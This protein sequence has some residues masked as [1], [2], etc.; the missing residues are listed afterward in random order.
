MLVLIGL[1][2]N[3]T[4]RIRYVSQ[5]CINETVNK[6]RAYSS[7]TGLISVHDCVFSRMDIF[8]P[9][10]GVIMAEGSAT[11]RIDTCIFNHCSS[12]CIGGCIFYDNTQSGDSTLTRL[13]VFNCGVNWGFGSF[14][15]FITSNKQSITISLL[16]ILMCE[17]KIDE[18][19]GPFWLNGGINGLSN[20]N[21]TMN[22]AM[23]E[24]ALVCIQSEKTLMKF[25][26][27]IDDVA[28]GGSILYFA[29]INEEIGHYISFSNF[30]H[31]SFIKHAYGII[32]S[33]QSTLEVTNCVFLDNNALFLF[34]ISPSSVLRITNSQYNHSGIFVYGD[35]FQKSVTSTIAT[36]HE[37]PLFNTFMCQA[38]VPF[39]STNTPNNNNTQKASSTNWRFFVFG[40]MFIIILSIGIYAYLIR[41]KNNKLDQFYS[42]SDLI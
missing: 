17:S 40:G 11:L 18:S 20:F 13:C 12:M 8:G 42:F 26:N 14:G 39:V 38:Q 10:G 41:Q 35:Y 28:D 21:S 37:I 32:Y 31:N 25:A 22:H 9:N 1:V 7:K 27:V 3:A 34:Q 33:N 5:N 4:D 16:S 19:Y 23:E 15:N 6:G 24:S 30:V 2:I 36:T 29:N